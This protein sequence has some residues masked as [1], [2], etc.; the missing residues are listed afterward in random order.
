MKAS[1]EHKVFRARKRASECTG[2][3]RTHCAAGRARVCVATKVNQIKNLHSTHTRARALTLALT[4]SQSQ[5][6]RTC[7]MLARSLARFSRK[8]RSTHPRPFQ[9]A[10]WLSPVRP[11]A[12]PPVRCRAPVQWQPVLAARARERA[13][14]SRPADGRVFE[15]RRRANAFQ[16]ALSSGVE[17]AYRGRE[18]AD[19]VR[20]SARQLGRTPPEFN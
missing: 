1:V 19:R 14:S 2:C 6:L 20:P 4:G 18:Q 16:G 9:P 5:T 13:S 17:P 15:G 7:C 3:T 12:R 8:Y 11:P 10:D